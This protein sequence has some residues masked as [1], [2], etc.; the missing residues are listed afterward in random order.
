MKSKARKHKFARL[1]DFGAV[2]KGA[3]DPDS[4][5]LEMYVPYC[6]SC[7]ENSQVILKGKANHV[8]KD[9]SQ[10]YLCKRC[11]YKFNLDPTHHSRFPE[12]V[13][14][15]VLDLAAKGRRPKEVVEEVTRE[16]KLRREKNITM[17]VQTVTNLISKYTKILL[18]FERSVQRKKASSIWYID[19]TYEIFPKTSPRGKKKFIWIT[20]V[21]E[22]ETRYW[23]AAHVFLRRTKKASKEALE[24]AVRRAKHQPCEV[25]CDGFQGHIGAIREVLPVACVET[26]TKEEAYGWINPIES[27]NALMRRMGIKKRGRFRSPVVLQNNVDLLRTYY[28]FLRPHKGLNGEIPARR[29]G[30]FYPH[31]SGWMEL[32]RFAFFRIGRT[33]AQ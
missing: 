18:G 13:V 3:Y 27:L 9:K 26:K 24:L 22:Y 16:S 6:P 32:I 17:S 4:F 33:K 7:G 20:N 8:L 30:I 15:R 25:R 11:N 10:R 2:K 31:V 23:P 21:L 12:W 19:D 1:D 29:A 14:E 28:N 5:S